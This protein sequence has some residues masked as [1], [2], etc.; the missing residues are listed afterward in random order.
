MPKEKKPNDPS[1]SIIKLF[2]FATP[3][4]RIMILIAIICSA[5]SGV[6]QPIS[7]LIYGSFISNLTGSLSDTSNILNA[8]F[9]HIYGS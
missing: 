3:K 5:A 7:I 4:E 1:V 6:L 8:T 2:R 9:L